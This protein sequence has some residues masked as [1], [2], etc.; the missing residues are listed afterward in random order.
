MNKFVPSLKQIEN[1]EKSED[2]DI[3]LEDTD[4][5]NEDKDDSDEEESENK[6]ENT[7]VLL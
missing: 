3:L 7:K 5:A 6:Y 4:F 2:D 1:K